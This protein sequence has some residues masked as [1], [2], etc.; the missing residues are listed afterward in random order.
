MKIVLKLLGVVFALLLLVIGV[1]RL[2]SESG[3]VVVLQTRTAA[4]DVAETRL[5][6]VD[7][8]GFAWLRSGSNASGW[9][10]RL[11]ANSAVTV[12]RGEIS[13]AANAQPDVSMRELINAEMRAK[14]GWADSYISLL[15][16]RDDAI[17]IRLI[18]SP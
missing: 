11:E 12:Q 10:Q 1:E 5:W 3:E 8:A 4:G 18:P 9:Y 6:V 16:G 14:Y 15:F 13:F 17:P 2:A 7:Q